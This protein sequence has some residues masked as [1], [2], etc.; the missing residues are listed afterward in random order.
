MISIPQMLMIGS[1]GRNSGKTT[2]A[3]EGIRRWKEKYPVIALKVTSMDERDGECPR[4]GHGCG[5]CSNLCGNY[6]IIEELD[7]NTA[8]DT[9]QLL[10]S[11]AARVYW[12]KSLRT[13]LSEGIKEFLRLI[14]PKAIIICESNS[15]RE[16]VKP[17]VFVI[18][19]NISD[20][21]IKVTAKNVFQHADR[22]I[23]KDMRTH[24]DEILNGFAIKEKNEEISITPA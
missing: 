18:M 24:A 16:V 7:P 5:A 8:K 21:L 3:M 19:H 9:S 22:V 23:N 6:E 17:G 4:G 11:G 15:L 12:L 10:K 20:D 1:T 2:F 13:H 14:P